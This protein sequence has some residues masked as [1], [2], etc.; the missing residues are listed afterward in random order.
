MREVALILIISI[1]FTFL[2][3]SVS[4]LTYSNKSGAIKGY[5][6][7]SFHLSRR[8]RKGKIIHTYQWQGVT[9]HFKDVTNKKLFITSPTKYAP[10][11]GG[12]CATAMAKGAIVPSDPKISAIYN[13][14]LYL[15]YSKD[16]RDAWQQS[17]KRYL[18]NAK[19]SWQKLIKRN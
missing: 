3:L 13:Q 14:Q 19:S 6:P 4:G 8:E 1:F 12:F 10:K 11:F 9:W 15:F 17:K 2:P 16:A 7:V 18:E 5:D